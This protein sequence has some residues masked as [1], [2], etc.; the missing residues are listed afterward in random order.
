MSAIFVC[1][2]D[3]VLDFCCQLVHDD[4]VQRL[5]LVD[6]G[7]HHDVRYAVVAVS[8]GRGFPVG[9]LLVVEVV[10]NSLQVWY[11]G[12]VFRCSST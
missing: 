3:L 8:L 12:V 4:V 2:L 1:A 5:R 6:E 11:D 10:T 9:A 7:F